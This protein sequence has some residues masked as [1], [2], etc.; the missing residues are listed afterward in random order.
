MMKTKAVIDRFEGDKAV[1]LVGEEE[2]RL[3]VPRA[4]LPTGVKEGTWLQV[5]VADD[6]VLSAT[7][8]QAETAKRKAIIEEKLAKLRRGDRRKS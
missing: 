4:S 8:D 6:R 1:L 3:V 2:D 7:I 5:D